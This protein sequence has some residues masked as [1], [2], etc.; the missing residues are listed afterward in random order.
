MKGAL[1][2]EPIIPNYAVFFNLHEFIFVEKRYKV[3]KGYYK[4]QKD[5]FQ[6]PPLKI[7]AMQTNRMHFKTSQEAS[8]NESL[9]K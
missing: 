7:I 6:K 9:P 3:Q 1:D 5:G 4:N 2:N 8:Q